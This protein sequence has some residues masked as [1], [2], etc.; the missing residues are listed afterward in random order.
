MKQN[1]TKTKNKQ[2][3]YQ[4]FNGWTNKNHKESPVNGLV[5]RCPKINFRKIENS[6]KF[7]RFV[8]ETICKLE[9]CEK[10]NRYMLYVLLFYIGVYHHN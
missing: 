1:L 6:Y 7:M 9:F 10:S 2:V 3:L 5:L 4:K 8:K